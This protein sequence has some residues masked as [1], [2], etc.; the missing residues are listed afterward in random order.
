MKRRPSDDDP[1][2]GSSSYASDQSDARNAKLL[3][4]VAIAFGGVLIV[5]LLITVVALVLGR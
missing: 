2:D 4:R 3:K 1:G 5:T